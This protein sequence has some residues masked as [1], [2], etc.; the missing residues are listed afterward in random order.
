MP[1]AN[2]RFLEKDRPIRAMHGT[3]RKPAPRPCTRL[4]KEDLPIGRRETKHEYA[5][6]DTEI[7]Y[8][9]HGA[10]VAHVKERAERTPTIMR[11]HDCMVPIQLMAEGEVSR[12]ESPS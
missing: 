1:C 10:K 12:S 8:D 6:D 7:A 4:G 5:E 11:N 2:A 9:E 3:Y